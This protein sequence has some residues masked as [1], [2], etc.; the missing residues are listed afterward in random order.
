MP[1]NKL[2]EELWNNYLEKPFQNIS[3][4]EY[5]EFLTPVKTLVMTI[6]FESWTAIRMAD[7]KQ[8]KESWGSKIEFVLSCVGFSVS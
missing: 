5:N 3:C 7:N 4:I 1:L 2:H 8:E 6:L